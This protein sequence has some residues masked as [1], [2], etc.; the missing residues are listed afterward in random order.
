MGLEAV[1]RSKGGW[2]DWGNERMMGLQDGF[3]GRGGGAG[4]SGRVRSGR[5][6]MAWLGRRG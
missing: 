5:L 2:Q 1:D 6:K 4:T 3:A